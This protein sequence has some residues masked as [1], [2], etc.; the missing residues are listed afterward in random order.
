MVGL[1]QTNLTLILG[2]TTTR[3]QV[4][5]PSLDKTLSLSKRHAIFTFLISHQIA[6]TI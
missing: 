5:I 3:K 2:I 6:I 4:V 1:L